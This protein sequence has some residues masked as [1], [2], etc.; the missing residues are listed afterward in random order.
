MRLT[1][2]VPEHTTHHQLLQLLSLPT[3][4]KGKDDSPG[5]SRTQRVELRPLLLVDIVVE[6]SR[7][8]VG[9]LRTS[10]DVYPAFRGRASA[11]P[12]LVSRRPVRSRPHCV[13]EPRHGS[14]F[15][16]RM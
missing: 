10:N 13:L 16:N 9:I 15:S 14:Q 11:A 2:L 5:W 3:R 8:F 4:T 7:S 6:T 1:D 12:A